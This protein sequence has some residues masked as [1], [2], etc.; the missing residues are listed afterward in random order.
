MGT[1]KS[2]LLAVL[3][4]ISIS[5]SA[6][7]NKWDLKK[8]VEYAMNNNITVKQQDI[9]A[10]L[11]QL[12]L[13]QSKLAQ[14]PTLN[15]QGN[16]GYSAGR[17]Q[18]PTNFSLITQGFVFSQYQLQSGLDVFNWFSKKNNIAA[19]ELSV[20]AAKASVDK[21]RNDIALNVAAAYLQALLTSEQIG[22]AQIQVDQTKAQLLHTRKL[23]DAGSLPELNAAEL[24]SQLARDS[25]SYVNAKA[26]Y[27]SAI[28]LLKAYMSLDMSTT[29][30]IDKPDV[31]TI[32]IDNISEMQPE[33]VYAL[34]LKNQPQQR[35]NEFRIA[36]AKKSIA[37]AR[38]AM[39]PSFSIFGSLGTSFNSRGQEVTGLQTIN[40]PLGKVNVNG[41]D[42][43][44][45]PL[46]PYTVPITGKSAYF[47][48]LD[49]NFRQ[50]VGVGVSIPILSSGSLKTNWQRARL[51]LTNYELQKESDDLALKQNIYNAYTNAV[52]AIAKY[53]ANVKTLTTAK[54]SFELAG[55]RY[56]LGLLSTYDY[57]T[58]QN[59][60]FKA[61]IDVLYA[62]YDYVFKM[63]VLEFYKGQGLKL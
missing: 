5:V 56:D 11:A 62:Q 52:N 51:N 37:S 8:C 4:G 9:Q 19:N 23:V 44:V 60:M 6:Q 28:I 53:N 33:A 35:V 36:S 48:Q 17:N 49:N 20:K 3:I 21:L 29:F 34:A 38:G 47:K 15:F 13:K 32:P 22:L 58:N 12:S 1:R 63:K 46:S 42:Y 16:T 45:F 27:E 40:P 24:E 26:S 14:N 7:D 18:D 50:S 43:S 30:D 57:I 59:N 39:Y 10:L 25:S 54:R 31:S 41:T 55:K 2:I 61:Q